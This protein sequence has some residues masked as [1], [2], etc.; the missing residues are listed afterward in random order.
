MFE[1]VP[2]ALKRWHAQNK[3]IRIFSSGSVLAQKLLFEH[4]DAGDLG[5][6]LNGY[7]DTNIGPK[8]D[9]RSYQRIAAAFELTAGEILFISDTDT[10]LNAAR[11]AGMETMFSVRPGN[12]PV[13]SPLHRTVT[14]FDFVFP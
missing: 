1:D 12:R 2:R 7:F 6:L 3:D 13:E 4:T 14:S 5:V 11:S 10:E 8:T 9:P